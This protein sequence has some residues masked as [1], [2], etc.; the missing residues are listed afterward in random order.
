M[1]QHKR[2]CSVIGSQLCFEC[3][4]AVFYYNVLKQLLS[5]GKLSLPLKPQQSS[6]KKQVNNSE[7]NNNIVMHS[8]GWHL[9]HVYISVM[10]CV[11]TYTQQLFKTFGTERSSMFSNQW[12]WY[13][14]IFFLFFPH[15]NIT[16]MC[17]FFTYLLRYF[18]GSVSQ[19][20]THAEPH[21]FSS[22]SY[23]PALLLYSYCCIAPDPSP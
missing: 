23:T 11:E 10:V 21:W 3:F 20:S 17:Y 8:A 2:L 13:C 5:W 1:D 22:Y 9:R 16:L 12:L 15:L 14:S 6:L 18:T 4:F 19:L 7:K